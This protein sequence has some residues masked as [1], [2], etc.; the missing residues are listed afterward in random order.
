MLNISKDKQRPQELFFPY[1]NFVRLVSIKLKQG[2][3]GELT[4]TDILSQNIQA[5]I[6][7]ESYQVTT[8]LNFF[9]SMLLFLVL[10]LSVLFFFF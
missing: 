10:S 6:Q 5:L 1:Q 9:Y 8:L 7:T 2:R 3:R 4:R